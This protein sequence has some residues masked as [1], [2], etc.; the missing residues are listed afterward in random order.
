MSSL[1]EIRNQL[2][3]VENI[4]QITTTMEMVASTRLHKTQAKAKQSQFYAAKVQELLEKLTAS[5]KDIIHSFFEQREVKKIGLVVISS[6]RGLC[7]PYNANIFFAVDQFLKDFSRETVDLI[8]IG[9]KAIDYYQ[10][11]KK[12]TIKN[13]FLGWSGKVSLTQIHELTNQL[14]KM[15][16][17]EKWDS[18]WVA[19][20][21]FYSI[22]HREV[23]LEKFLPIGDLKKQDRQSLPNY[24]FEPNVDQLYLQILPRYLFTKIQTMIQEAYASELAARI[25]AMKNAAKNAE[26]MVENLILVRNKMRQ[27]AITKEM[28]EIMAGIGE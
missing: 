11:K 7:G 8:L 15:F 16:L 17:E 28:L 13:Q 2:R 19:Y 4:K 1:K 3:S 6:D 22:T 5:S 27:G 10:R 23:T 20:T 14:T 24:I 25:F 18:I 12:W 21:K 9:R 26:E